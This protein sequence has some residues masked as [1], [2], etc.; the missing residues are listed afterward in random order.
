MKINKS[1]DE[2]CG[3][4]AC[5]S[6]C[7]HSAIMMTPDKLGF[8]YPQVDTDKCVD[9]GL[10][11]KVCNFK[12][13]YS[14]GDG[15]GYFD[16]PKVLGGRL[17]DPEQL[18]KSQS[19]GAAFAF[20]DYIIGNHGVVYGAVFTEDFLVTHNRCADMSEI[21]KLRGSKYIQSDIRAIFPQIKKDL[22]DGVTVLFI[23]TPCQV[24]GLKSYIDKK[25]WQ[26]LYLIDLV[27][28]GVPSPS[29]W[30]DY[31]KYVE[32][33]RHDKVVGCVFRDKSFGWK[34]HIESFQLMHKKPYG[35]HI[36]RDLFYEHY[37]LRD[38]CHSCPFTNY[39]RI[40]DVTIGDFWGHYSRSRFDDNKG[41]SLFLIN[42]DKGEFLFNQIKPLI[43]FFDSNIK[44]C[45]QEQLS[46]PAIS[47]SKREIFLSDYIEKGFN[48]VIH[49]YAFT[50][51][52]QRLKVGKI[53]FRTI[54]EK[55]KWHLYH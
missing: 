43:Y 52:K 38:S 55:I 39:N 6:I 34:S 44:V 30:K 11:V 16:M 10:C 37:I 14:R 29:I 49:K 7:P 8:L 2:C 48:Y 13:D 12:S 53:F 26:N 22:I 42:T 54:V 5:E 9:C 17:K 47:N 27:C 21:L 1:I 19:G 33:K 3:C 51:Y 35:N 31:I 15:I 40:S 18:A 45:E 4:T 28:H 36:F 25:Y 32:H 41:I 50:G 46:H 24:A 23:G 20:A